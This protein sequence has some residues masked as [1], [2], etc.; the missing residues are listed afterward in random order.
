ML[1]SKVVAI[2]KKVPTI[3]L[4][5]TQKDGDWLVSKYERPLKKVI[6]GKSMP[7]NE[8]ESEDKDIVKCTIDDIVKACESLDDVFLNKCFANGRNCAHICLVSPSSC[9]DDNDKRC[10]LAFKGIDCFDDKGKCIGSDDDLGV[11]LLY[12][13]NSSDCL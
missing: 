13:L 4:Y 11:K 3:E 2:S 10:F 6:V 8:V 12:K 7:L 5:L 1:G 9:C